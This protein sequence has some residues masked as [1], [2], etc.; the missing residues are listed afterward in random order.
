MFPILSNRLWIKCAKGLVL[1]SAL[2]VFSIPAKSDQ[3]LAKQG[4]AGQKS[5]TTNGQLEVRHLIQVVLDVNPS[6]EALQSSWQA[7]QSRVGRASALDDPM[8]SYSFAPQTYDLEGQGFGQKIQLS[9]KLPW[10]GKL[11]LRSDSAQFEARAREESID[12]LRLKL[13][14]ITARSFADWFYIH[15]ALRINQLNQDLWDEFHRIAELKYS[16]GRVNKQDVLRAE[17]EQAMLE[18]KAITLTRKKGNILVK[19]NTLL[20]RSPDK[21]LPP[22]TALPNVKSLPAPRQLQQMALES[23]PELKV[24]QAKQQANDAQVKLAEREYYPDFN[25]N[26]GYNSLWNQDEKRL[27]LGVGINIPLG[28]SKRDS[29]VSEKRSLVQQTKWQITDKQRAIM[30]AVQRAYNNLEES[31]HVLNLYK[32]KLLPLSEENLQAAKADY[33]SAKGGFLDLVSAEKNLIQT[34]LNYVQAQADYYR[35]LA[36]L[37]R[38]VGRPQLLSESLAT[39][40][41]SSKTNTGKLK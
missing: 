26:A 12:L 16:S 1:C 10:F 8:L 18:H 24:L 40:L 34:Q 32:R 20:N 21:T 5:L 36:R 19:L 41:H 38:R 25:V 28:Q 30:G 29:K 4:L 33:E 17:V 39:S 9:Q 37:A 31:R 11:D 14:E 27:T 15:E 13:I 35:H 3:D 7:A 2:L 23:H 6:I 22:P